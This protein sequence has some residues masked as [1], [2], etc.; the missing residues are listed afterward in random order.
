MVPLPKPSL[1]YWVP[2]DPTWAGQELLLE[3]DRAEH[4]HPRA[5][6][7]AALTPFRV[8]PPVNT[9]GLLISLEEQRH[10]PHKWESWPGRAG[11]NPF[12][13]ELPNAATETLPKV[14]FQSIPVG[15]IFIISYIPNELS[16]FPRS[17]IFWKE[18]TPS[19]LSC[20]PLPSGIFHLL[21]DP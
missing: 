20:F 7:A 6:G 18:Q 1:K 2:S 21:P 19:N 9:V 17:L 4:P 5:V 3:P 10:F 15:N 13:H 16:M 11:S 14:C 8:M 12:A